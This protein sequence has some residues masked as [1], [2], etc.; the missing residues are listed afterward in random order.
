MEWQ[1]HPSFQRSLYVFA[2]IEIM[3]VT[4][5]SHKI[6]SGLRPI[7]V[8]LTRNSCKDQAYF[9][10]WPSRSAIVYVVHLTGVKSNPK[11]QFPIFTK[12]VR[13]PD[14]I[15]RLIGSM[16]QIIWSPLWYVRWGVFKCVI[17]VMSG[18]GNLSTHPDLHICDGTLTLMSKTRPVC[19]AKVDLT[20]SNHFA[21]SITIPAESSLSGSNSTTELRAP[22]KINLRRRVIVIKVSA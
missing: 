4:E 12:F 15:G 14:T 2:I 8:Y 10:I 19:P 6:I 22:W 7:W 21:S 20:G 9:C 16:F 5:H 1:I 13:I 18:V 3:S 11:N 17:T